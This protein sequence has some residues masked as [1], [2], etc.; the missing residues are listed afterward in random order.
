M[1]DIFDNYVTSKSESRPIIYAYSDPR[2]PGCLKV[3][4]T[5][6]PV[7]ERMKEHYPTLLP[8]DQKPY[9]VVLTEPA[10]RDDGSVFMDHDVHK[11]LEARK[12]H[13]RKNPSGKKTEWFKCT[14]DDVR[15]AI[16]AVR[17]G[18]LG[19]I[20]RTQTFRMRPE[21]QRAVSMTKAYFESEEKKNRDH[22]AK[23]R[24]NA[25]MRFGKTF[26]AYELAKAM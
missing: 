4:Y 23:C 15:A 10:M 12:I 19:S 21:Q 3:G 6:R 5:S 18:H 2:Y 17:T 13:K 1:A 14:A 9:T 22:S 25:K 16:V 24:W 8:N 11:V 7:E 26:T 20:P